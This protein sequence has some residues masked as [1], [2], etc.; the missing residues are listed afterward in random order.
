[1]NFLNKEKKKVHDMKSKSAKQNEMMLFP[2]WV[3]VCN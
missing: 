3:G 1:M 2:F